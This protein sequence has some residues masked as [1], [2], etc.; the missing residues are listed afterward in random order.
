M[1]SA[2]VHRGPDDEG[3]FSES[4]SGV[5]LG[6]RRLSIIDVA[7]GHQPMFNENRSIVV[8]QNGELYNSPQL[9]ARAL[10]RGHRLDTTCDT[11]LLPHLYEELGDDLF[12]ALDG[13]YA[14]SIFDR[15]RQRLLLG[16]D[17]FGEKPLFFHHAN[18]VLTWASE[19]TALTKGLPTT[20]ELNLESLDAYFVLG[21]VPGPDTLLDGICQ[22]PPGHL[23]EWSAGSDSVEMRPYWSPPAAAA[24]DV[25]DTEEL[26]VE[27]EHLLKESV[28][29]RLIADVPLGVFLSGGMDSA[30]VASLATEVSS[31]PVKTFT[32]GYDIGE[33]SEA[34]PARLAA[35]QLGTQ[36]HEV[37][38]RTDDLAALA[39]DVF[40]RLDQ[41][42]ADQALVAAH[43]VSRF[44]REEVKVVVGGEGADELFGG[45]PR[46]RWL[47]R[48]SLLRDKVPAPGRAL[49]SA[50]LAKLPLSGRTER[51]SLLVDTDD[52]VSRHLNWVTSGRSMLRG[53]VYGPQLR[54]RFS[55][56]ILE[57]RLKDLQPDVDTARRFMLLDQLVW[58]PD[59]VL[60][61]ADR[62]S[63]LASLEVRTPFLEPRVAE[64]AACLD[65]RQHTGAGGKAILR[66]ITRRRIGTDSRAPRKVAFRVPADDWLRGPLRPILE[67]QVRE[68][69][70]YSDGLFERSAVEKLIEEHAAGTHSWADVLWPLLVL[71]FWMDRVLGSAPVG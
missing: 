14:V 25:V 13:M 58:L 6:A 7:G 17:R 10:E 57:Q 28:R 64:A 47:A 63:M 8:A 53:R 62:A 52:D 1:L 66:E 60:A 20:P 40:S 56:S 22:L 2:L 68:S 45:Y 59:D 49:T 71:G 9:R 50:M 69:A 33:V 30:L 38:L 36:H 15:Q 32:V 61:K 44:A 54:A 3:L 51:L 46:Y 12:Y 11:E 18:G 4:E 34:E 5:S 70:L 67:R 26:I 23:L 65:G 35:T 19:L 41:P 29:S 31:E 24:P 43:A 42:I 39:E 27:V 48:G 16:R 21:Y 55:G 37:T